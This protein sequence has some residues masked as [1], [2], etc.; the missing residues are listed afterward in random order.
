[1]EV[2]G[3]HT[4]GDLWKLP[5][6]LTSTEDETDAVLIFLREYMELSHNRIQSILKENGRAMPHPS[7]ASRASREGVDGFGTRG[8]IA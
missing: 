1:V 4:Q 7:L 8:S 2:E 3:S 6:P 5:L